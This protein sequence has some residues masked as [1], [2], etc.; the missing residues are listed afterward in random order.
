MIDKKELTTA[1]RNLSKGRD[2]IQDTYEE[3][4]DIG[5]IPENMTDEVHEI[6]AEGRRAIQHVRELIA[7]YTRFAER[8]EREG[9]VK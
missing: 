5:I 2:L 8:L 6:Q 1:R 4:G 7:R 9:L 3:I